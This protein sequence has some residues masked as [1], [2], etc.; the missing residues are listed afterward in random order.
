MG[1]DKDVVEAANW[2]DNGPGWVGLLLLGVAGAVVTWTGEG[3]QDERAALE[4]TLEERYAESV[5][6]RVAVNRNHTSE[7]VI[8]DGVERL[9]CDA[10][11]DGYPECSRDPRPTLADE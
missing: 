6:I 9:D 10:T 2:V 11:D 7:D 8:L 1:I 5:S 3:L 4:Q